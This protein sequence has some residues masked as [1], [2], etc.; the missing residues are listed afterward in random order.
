MKS[1]SDARQRILDAAREVFVEKGLSGARMQEIAERAQI[2]KAMLH[3]YFT[4]KETLYETVVSTV[5]QGVMQRASGVLKEEGVPTEER[6]IRLVDTYLESLSKNPDMPRLV[7]MDLLSGGEIVMKAFS[8]AQEKAGLVGMRP[9]INL[10]NRGMLEGVIHEADPRHTMISIIG[11]I[12][13]SFLTEPL[14]SELLQID[15]RRHGQFFNERRLNIM[16]ILIHG[17]VKERDSARVST[18]PREDKWAKWLG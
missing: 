6:L 4:N 7:M 13:F 5:V 11:M 9:V 8:Q 18:I 10:L 12:A 14:L 16:H 1:E 3:Y 15:P 2:S 17:V